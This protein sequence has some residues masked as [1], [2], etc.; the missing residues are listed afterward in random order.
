MTD[1]QFAEVKDDNYE[2]FIRNG[3][4]LIDFWAPWCGPC[5]AQEPILESVAEKYKSAVTI[6]KCNVDENTETADTLNIQSIPSLVLY[7]NGEMV[8]HFVGVTSDD[9]LT[10][11][12]DFELEL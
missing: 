2:T 7:N 12:I 4:V 10:E 3:C 9:M 5:R 8:E 6:G 1:G 11:I